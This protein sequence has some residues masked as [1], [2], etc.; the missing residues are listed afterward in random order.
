VICR[1][2]GSGPF[3]QLGNH[4]WR[5]HPGVSSEEYFDKYGGMIPGLRAYHKCDNPSCLNITKFVNFSKGYRDFC[6][7]GCRIVTTTGRNLQSKNARLQAVN[8][9]RNRIQN[10][11]YIPYQNIEEISLKP[12]LELKGF[13]HQYIYVYGSRNEKY[14]LDFYNPDTKVNIEVD[15]PSHSW[16]ETISKDK[17]RDDILKSQGLKVIRVSLSDAGNLASGT[18]TLEEISNGR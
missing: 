5:T 1:I 3:H 7:S 4:L 14:I 6:S 11:T 9:Y 8:S 16:G 17:I 18:L 12:I 15:G 2:C 10:K 13:K